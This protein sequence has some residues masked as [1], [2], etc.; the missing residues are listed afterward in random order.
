MFVLRMTKSVTTSIAITGLAI[1]LTTALVANANAGLSGNASDQTNSTSSPA[2]ASSD[3]AFKL[4]ETA[5]GK[6]HSRRLSHRH[7]HLG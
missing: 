4:I 3:Q 6:T 5:F 7:N 2:I 1:S